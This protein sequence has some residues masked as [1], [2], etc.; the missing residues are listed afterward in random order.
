M[1]D[2]SSEDDEIL[3]ENDAESSDS[4]SENN[5]QNQG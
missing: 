3:Q 2:S 4:D 1:S 5:L